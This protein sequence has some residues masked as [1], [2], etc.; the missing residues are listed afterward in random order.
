MIKEIIGE[1]ALEDLHRR[2][3]NVQRDLHH[4]IASELLDLRD[5]VFASPS[6]FL[7]ASLAATLESGPSLSSVV[8][9]CG[10]EFSSSSELDLNTGSATSP[11]RL[12]SHF[13]PTKFRNKWANEVPRVQAVTMDGDEAPSQELPR[14]SRAEGL[15]YVPVGVKKK[16]S[17]TF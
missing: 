4:R 8:S 2:G 11:S 5:V 13:L 3:R 14:M 6:P 10:K 17:N 12:G 7:G 9:T 1:K 16:T 15:D